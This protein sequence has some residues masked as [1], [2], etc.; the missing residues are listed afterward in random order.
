MVELQLPKLM[1]RVRFPSLAPSYGRKLTQEEV[2]VELKHPLVAVYPRVTSTYETVAPRASP[3]GSGRG[4]DCTS[5][6]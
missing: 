6:D 2:F 3:G 1:A 5:M 4:V